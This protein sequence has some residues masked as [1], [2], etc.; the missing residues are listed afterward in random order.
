MYIYIIYIHVYITHTYTRWFNSRPFHPRSLEVT[1]PTIQK[2][3]LRLH[4]P[5][6]GHQQNCQVNNL[7]FPGDSKC[8]FSSLVGGHGKP[9]ER[10]TFQLNHQDDI[11]SMSHPGW[12]MTGSLWIIAYEIIPKYN[13]VVCIVPYIYSNQTRFFFSKS[14]IKPFELRSLGSNNDW[15]RSRPRW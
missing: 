13:W 7:F 3:H 9:L 12:L 14:R 5:Q 2:G 4:H 8:P 15:S 1:M 10:G 11:L 6:K